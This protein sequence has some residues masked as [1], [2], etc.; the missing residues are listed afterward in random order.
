M[1]SLHKD[2]EVFKEII[3]RTSQYTSYSEAIIEKDYYA[4]A[5]LK[6]LF[7]EDFGFVFKGGTSLSKAYHII[8]RFSE[9]IDLTYLDKSYLNRRKRK[10]LKYK[11]V[12]VVEKFGL[13]VTNLE[14]TRSKRDFNQYHIS[15]DNLFPKSSSIKKDVIVELAFQ[16]EGY[17]CDIMPV[18]SIIGDYLKENGFDEIIEKY[19]LKEFNI[20]VQTLLRTFIDKLF[21]ICDYYLS[22]RTNNHSRHIY[23]LHRIS[24]TIK[25]DNDFMGIFLLVRDERKESEICFSANSDQKL[26]SL[27]D[28]IITKNIYKNDYKNVTANLISDETTYEECIASLKNINENLIKLG[29]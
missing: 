11:L 9:D 24:K 12:E 13:K 25:Y 7:Y 21:A 3:N 23:D 1:M 14:N 20:T 2:V 4:T 15:Y 18:G 6:A 8:N 28:E 27:I 26:S 29:L 5:I 17:P 16:E 22:N 19:D 10:E